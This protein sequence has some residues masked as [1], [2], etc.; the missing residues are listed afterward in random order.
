MVSY[1]DIEKKV[2]DI[3][4][5]QLGVSLEDVQRDSTFSGDLGA[6]DLDFMELIMAF[7]EE[8]EFDIDEDTA[9]DL[10]SVQNVIDLLSTRSN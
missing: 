2:K 5:E 7:E 6:D 8:F 4:A 10:E 3:I 1:D 9:D